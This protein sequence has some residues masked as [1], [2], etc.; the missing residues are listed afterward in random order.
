MIIHNEPVMKAGDPLDKAK[1]VLIMSHGRGDSAASFIRFSEELE[2]TGFSFLAIQAIQNTWYPYS[3]LAP[4]SQNEPQLSMSLGG[5]S[6]LLDNVR[7]LGFKPQDI[8]FLGFSQGACLT[9][10]FCARNAQRYGGI[11]ALTGGLLGEEI[12]TSNYEGDF[13]GTNV[14]IGASDHDPHVPEY[15]IDESEVILG[16]MGATV[17]KKIYPGMGHV[18]NRDEISIAREILSGTFR[19]IKK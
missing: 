2:M 17:T 5:L 19:P 7:G 13:Q 8:Y 14:F 12:N 15:R 3:F 4:L 1:K 6:E 9:L 11:I 10:E 16:N 18:I